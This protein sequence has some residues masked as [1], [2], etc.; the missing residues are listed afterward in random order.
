MSDWLL[1]PLKF[2]IETSITNQSMAVAGV[3]L[4]V[5]EQSRWKCSVLSWI[6]DWLSRSK[7][8]L[9]R[10]CAITTPTRYNTSDIDTG[11][12]RWRAVCACLESTI[13]T[14]CYTALRP[15]WFTSFSEC[16]TTPLGSCFKRRDDPRPSRCFADYT[17]CRLSRDSTRRPCWRSSLKVRNTV[18]SAYLDCWGRQATRYCARNLRSSSA[19]LLAQPSR[20]TYFAACGFRYST[21]AVW[22]S[23]YLTVL[24]SSSLTVFKSRLKTHLFHMAHNDRQW[25]TWSDLLRHRLWSYDLT[26]VPVCI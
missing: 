8:Q 15:R 21:P 18:T 22:Y 23:Q 19:P 5:A 17:G 14:L 1:L 2:T 26:A 3:N 25:L 9:W 16:K 10:S 20:R 7:P 11:R 6:S 13:A 12:R 24:D 4:P